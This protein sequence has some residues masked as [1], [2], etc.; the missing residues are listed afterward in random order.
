M[1]RVRIGAVTLLAAALSLVACHHAPQPIPPTPHS[2]LIANTAFNVPAGSWRYYTIAVTSVMLSPHL[3]GTF[4]ASGGSGNDIR[5]LV[6]TETDY[7]NWSNGHAVYPEYN[8][9]QVTTGSF[10]VSLNTGTHY[11]VYDNTFSSVSDKGV[12]T[13]V[14][15]KYDTQP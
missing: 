4:T 3:E 14:H 15:L 12:T 13:T 1:K 7:V 10:D 5:V 11:L 8:S 9:G 2:D 6:M